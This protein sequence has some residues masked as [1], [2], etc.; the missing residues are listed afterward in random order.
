MCVLILSVPI[1]INHVVL[2]EPIRNTTK[3]RCQV[4]RS[5]LESIA[6]DFIELTAQRE[7]KEVT[8]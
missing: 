4:G 1:E 3:I 7:K 2:N 6:Y 5:R 8:I